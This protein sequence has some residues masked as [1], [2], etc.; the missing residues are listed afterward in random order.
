LNRPLPSPPGPAWTHHPVRDPKEQLVCAHR[1]DVERGQSKRFYVRIHSDD[2]ELRGFSISYPDYLHRRLENVVAVMSL[3]FDP[4]P[5][6]ASS[7]PPPRAQG[8][9]AEPMP[10]RYSVFQGTAFAVASDLFLTNAH[11]V[12]RCRA[13]LL[14]EYGEAQLFKSSDQ[15]DLALLKAAQGAVPIPIASD[16]AQLGEEVFALGY[17]LQD[18]LQNGLNLTTGVVSSL[19]G[20]GGD[21]NVLQMSVPVHPG[22]SGG[23]LI[24]RYGR[25]A[26]VVTAKLS[27]KVA[28]KGGLVPEGISFAVNA[29]AV[30]TFLL[31]KTTGMPILRSGEFSQLIPVLPRGNAERK[32]A[33]ITKEVSKAVTPVFCVRQRPESVPAE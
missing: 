6:F 5:S 11:N 19:K 2:S 24:D 17:P 15:L 1:A 32:I 18:I 10:D 29:Q 13:I 33:D 16:N 12:E 14:G 25:V 23:P 8:G 21:N 27:P 4:F 31:G 9:P 7:A 26:G 28:L 30:R 3:D 22:N 20:L